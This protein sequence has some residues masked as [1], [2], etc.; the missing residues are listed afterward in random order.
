MSQRKKTLRNQVVEAWNDASRS[1]GFRVVAP[2]ALQVGRRS[3]ACIALLPDFG[4]SHGMVVGGIV[5]PDFATDG[6][7]IDC[8]REAGMYCSFINLEHYASFDPTVFKETLA[9]WG[10]FGTSERRPV[11][12]SDVRSSDP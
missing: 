8:A 7:L 11:W 3:A 9:D 12:L 10:F 1:L 6:I 2:F 5:S 4:G